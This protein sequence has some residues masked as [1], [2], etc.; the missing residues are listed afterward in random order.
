MPLYEYKCWKC[1]KIRE[2]IQK[3]EDRSK[4]TQICDKCL[5]KMEPIEHSKPAKFQWGKGG[6]FNG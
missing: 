3:F 1:G 4:R 6:P 5:S 2:V